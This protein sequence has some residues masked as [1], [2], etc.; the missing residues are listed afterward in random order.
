MGKCLV[1]WDSVVP[2]NPLLMLQQMA[3]ETAA[4]AAFYH[5]V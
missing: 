5:M 2:E 3:A 4:K 1:D